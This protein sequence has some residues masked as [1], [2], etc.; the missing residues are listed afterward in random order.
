MNQRQV[1]P[2]W[3]YYT[4]GHVLY[5]YDLCGLDDDDEIET[6]IPSEIAIKVC[7][8]ILDLGPHKKGNAVERVIELPVK[9]ADL[10][11]T[12]TRTFIT[13]STAFLFVCMRPSI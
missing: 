11:D 3:K 9:Y 2:K 8:N 12:F 10:S 5:R 4:T 1:I 6:V 13:L 7:N